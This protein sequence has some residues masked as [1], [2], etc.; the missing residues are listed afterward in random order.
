MSDTNDKDILKAGG[1]ILTG[2]GPLVVC[3]VCGPTTLMYAG[4]IIYKTCDRC[5]RLL[6]D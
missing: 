3:N 4:R 5:R 1:A 2:P 6:N